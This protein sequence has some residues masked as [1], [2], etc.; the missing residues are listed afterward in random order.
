MFR[1][2]A[3]IVDYKRKVQTVLGTPYYVL[4]N[5]QREMKQ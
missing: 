1:H 3:V 5:Y 4:S 2:M